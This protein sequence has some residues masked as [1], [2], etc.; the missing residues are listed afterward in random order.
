VIV[1]KQSNYQSLDI[2]AND[3]VVLSKVGHITGGPSS[4][5]RAGDTVIMP[6]KAPDRNKS[7]PKRNSSANDA[8]DKSAQDAAGVLPCLN[9]NSNTGPGVAVANSKSPPRAQSAAALPTSP[10]QGGGPDAMAA[11]PGGLAS[12]IRRATQSSSNLN[13]PNRFSS[14]INAA[15]RFGHDVQYSKS[16]LKYLGECKSVGFSSKRYASPPKYRHIK[17]GDSAAAMSSSHGYY[18]EAEDDTDSV[19]S[20]TMTR[21]AGVG[22]GEPSIRFGGNK[23]SFG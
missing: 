23:L 7:K 3:S 17:N 15:L 20:I 13:S 11:G 10:I 12:L 14:S 21:P 18:H 22:A 6:N 8:R 19:H 16:H 1:G 2:V 9:G 5:A 4:F